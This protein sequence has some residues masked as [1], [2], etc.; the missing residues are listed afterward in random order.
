MY[1]DVCN[2][3]Y[4]TGPGKTDLIYTK[5]TCSYYDTYLLY[6]MCYPKSIS[7][8]HFLMDVCIY[9]DILVTIWF[10]EKNITFNT[11][12]QVKFYVNNHRPGH[13]FKIFSYIHTVHTI[14]HNMHSHIACKF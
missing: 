12:N 1:T 10:I 7:F 14:V 13:V 5:C 4:M 11:K 6:C 3:M 2:F 8:I 9:D